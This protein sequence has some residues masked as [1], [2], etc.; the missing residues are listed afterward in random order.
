MT[1]ID[2]PAPTWCPRCSAIVP[3]AAAWQPWPGPPPPAATALLVALR[4][5]DGERY[6]DLGDY[7]P[8]GYWN[9]VGGSF[10]HAVTP[11]AWRHPPALPEFGLL[12]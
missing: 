6:L 9:L 1:A 4:G 2:I 11:Y 12:T 8:Q 3:E 7:H 10:T 5:D